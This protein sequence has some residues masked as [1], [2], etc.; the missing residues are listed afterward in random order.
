[1]VR[2]PPSAADRLLVQLAAARGTKVSG[3]QL[4]RWRAQ[5]TPLLPANARTFP[6]RPAGG[7]ASA[8]DPAMV[9]L[10]VWLGQHSRPGADSL[11][12]ALGAF[13]T[14]LPVPDATVREAFVR[15]VV[16][17]TERTTE[18]LGP[19][20]EQGDVQEW[21]S[22]QAD[23][24]AQ[25]GAHRLTGVNR[26]IRA[27]DKQMQQLPALAELRQFATGFDPDRA[28]ADPLD[29]T[30]LLFHGLTAA[31]AG[32]R[33]I[34]PDAIARIARSQAGREAPQYTARLLETDPRDPLIAVRNTPAHQ[35]PGLPAD[36]T[37]NHVVSVAR[38]APLERLRAG[39]T[40][41]GEIAGWAQSLCLAVEAEIAS[42]QPGPA[43]FEWFLGQF[44]GIGR[45]YLVK[46]L[47]EP[48]PTAGQQALSAVELVF[49]LDAINSVLATTD[50]DGHETMRRLAPPFLLKLAAVEIP[51]ARP[52]EV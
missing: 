37:I 39:W 17:S 46:G 20:P 42:K 28:D 41:A 21:V 50:S 40:A 25:Q 7:S 45:T 6:G 13:G 47:A 32:P 51:R 36:S 30:G 29:N 31:V 22:D 44:F 38:D 24:I 33:G 5:P 12:L 16:R 8:A 9:D 49:T 3:R 34:E 23:A 2:T 11:Y 19:M 43:C 14:G 15:Q 4:E 52:N 1:M 35:L 26:R 18:R 48:S 27:I 10:V